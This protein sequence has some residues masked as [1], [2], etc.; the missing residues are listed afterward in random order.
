MVDYFAYSDGEVAFLHCVKMFLANNNQVQKMRDTEE[1]VDG[2]A[3]VSK[4]KS[5]L[6]VGKY[7]PRIGTERSVKAFGRYLMQYVSR[8]MDVFEKTYEKVNK[9][10]FPTLYEVG[11]GFE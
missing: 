4:F 11:L 10:N 1:L 7:I 3:S 8:G 6:L 5:K 2:C 9:K